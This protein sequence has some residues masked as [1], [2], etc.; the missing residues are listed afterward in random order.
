MLFTIG[1]AGRDLDDLVAA[2]QA[3]GVE[4]V[5]DVRE[6]PISR[7]P[8]FAKSAL[9][10]RLGSSGIDYLHERDLGCPKAIRHAYR[11]DNDWDG[12]TQRYLAHLA[13]QGPAL[14][15]VGDRAAQTSCALLCAERD[16][17]QCHRTFV[18]EAVA[19]LL[20]HELS[21]RHIVD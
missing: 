10:D 19:A 15:R 11:Q 21:I 3:N 12:Y 7:K 5:I 18:A 16:P 17:Q 13:R 2:L 6:L 14:Q 4:C 8:G 1:Y 9:R 20:G